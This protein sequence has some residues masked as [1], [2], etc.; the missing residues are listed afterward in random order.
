MTPRRPD[1][2][3]EDPELLPY[4]VHWAQWLAIIL[5]SVVILAAF[6]LVR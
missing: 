6:L 3:P 2:F 4:E 5:W 1:P